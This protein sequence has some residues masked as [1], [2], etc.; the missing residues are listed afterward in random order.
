MNRHYTSVW[1]LREMY[2]IFISSIRVEISIG[3][4]DVFCS[5]RVYFSADSNPSYKNISFAHRLEEKQKS[6]LIFQTLYVSI[7]HIHVLSLKVRNFMI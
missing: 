2:M 7:M 3:N 1:S 4:R 5:M 6:P